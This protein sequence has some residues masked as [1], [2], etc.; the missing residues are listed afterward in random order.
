MNA[1]FKLII[2]SLLINIATG[3]VIA[4]FPALQVDSSL[5]GGLTYVVN[6]ESGFVNNMERP[7]NPT[8]PA[9]DAADASTNLL[10]L[11]IIGFIMNF[12]S[13]VSQYLYGFVNLLRNIFGQYLEEGLADMIFGGLTAVFN[14]IYIYGIFSLITGKR[15]DLE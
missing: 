14:L 13:T 3:A 15:V 9:E 5:T 10:D 7:I 11:N 12:G 4:A 6:K 1:I 2:I 8:S